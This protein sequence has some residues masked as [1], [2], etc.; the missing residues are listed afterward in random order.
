[1]ASTP[2]PSG[3]R[4]QRKGGSADKRITGTTLQ[5][6]RAQHFAAHPLCVMCEAKGLVTAATELDHIIALCNGGTDTTDNRQGL[7]SDCHEIKTA[8]DLGYTLRQKQTIGADGWPV[9]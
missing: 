2:K 5:N 4:H 7:C 8:Q 6:I 9:T 3:G 1:M